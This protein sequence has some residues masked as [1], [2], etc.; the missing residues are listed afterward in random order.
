[1]R[2]SIEPCHG[3]DWDESV[4][5]HKMWLPLTGSDAGSNATAKQALSASLKIPP[6]ALSHLSASGMKMPEAEW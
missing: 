4:P 3:T 5:C 6:K 2:Q 1:M